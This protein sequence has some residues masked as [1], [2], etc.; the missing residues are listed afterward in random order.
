MNFELGLQR[1]IAM[2]CYEAPA[3]MVAEKFL[4]KKKAQREF[5]DI[6]N[7]EFFFDDDD[8]VLFQD[9]REERDLEVRG[10]E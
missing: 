2:Y 7:A 4:S 1:Q 6:N 8:P 10:E 3:A 5:I 9:F